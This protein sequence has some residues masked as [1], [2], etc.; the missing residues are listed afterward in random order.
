MRSIIG[1]LVKRLLNNGKG[2]SRL[3]TFC[4]IYLSIF[5]Q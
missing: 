1:N 4:E 5:I 2:L 3:F